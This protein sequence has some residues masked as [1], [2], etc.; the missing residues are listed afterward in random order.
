MS[1]KFGIDSNDN[2]ICV[3]DFAKSGPQ[4]NLWTIYET[5]QAHNICH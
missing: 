1:K 4:I 5:Q 2:K 3:P